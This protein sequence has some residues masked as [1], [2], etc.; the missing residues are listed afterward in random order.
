MYDNLYGLAQLQ[1]SVIRPPNGSFFAASGLIESRHCTTKSVLGVFWKQD[2]TQSEKVKVTKGKGTFEMNVSTCKSVTTTFSRT[3]CFFS[4]SGN[5]MR[6][7][8][9]MTPFFTLGRSG[10]SSSDGS[11]YAPR[12][13]QVPWNWSEEIGIEWNTVFCFQIDPSLVIFAFVGSPQNDWLII[14]QWTKFLCPFR[15]GSSC[16]SCSRRCK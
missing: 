16:S 12:F 4:K 2:E 7:A 8:F 10:I 1:E 5:T 13:L 15:G 9:Q 3:Y 11:V 14:L 6:W